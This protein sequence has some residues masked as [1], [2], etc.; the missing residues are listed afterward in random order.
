[1]DPD[2]LMAM[3]M[4]EVEVENAAPMLVNEVPDQTLTVVEPITVSVADTFMDPGWRP[5][6][7]HRYLFERSGGY[8]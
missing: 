3:D 4:F 8:G 5:A 1:M 6:E 7:L 2:G